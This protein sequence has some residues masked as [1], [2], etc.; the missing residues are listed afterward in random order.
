VS[1]LSTKR[2]GETA[3]KSGTSMATPHVGGTAALY[4]STHAG[5]AP[6][7]VERRLT[8]DSTRTNTKSKNGALIRLV[9]AS[10]Y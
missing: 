8:M 7:A 10:E 2:G 9:D 4:L 3:N 1:I 5:A 6:A